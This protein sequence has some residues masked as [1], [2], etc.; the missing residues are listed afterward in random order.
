MKTQPKTFSF[1][2]SVAKFLYNL[3]YSALKFDVNH[4]PQS[5]MLTPT[6]IIGPAVVISVYYIYTSL[7]LKY[8]TR[9]EL[10]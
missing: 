5:E 6:H 2:A 1:S 3:S 8:I 7:C 10:S 9:T 4:M